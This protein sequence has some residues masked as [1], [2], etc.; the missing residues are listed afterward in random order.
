MSWALKIRAWAGL[1]LFHE[2]WAL[3]FDWPSN[4]LN[5][6]VRFSGP[7]PKAGLWPT[8]GLGPGLGLG[9][10]PSLW[11]YSVLSG[12]LERSR[13]GKISARDTRDIL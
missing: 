2:F 9:S 1:E 7:F 12:L 6:M 4:L 10:D 11:F 8:P 5:K 3:A 13:R